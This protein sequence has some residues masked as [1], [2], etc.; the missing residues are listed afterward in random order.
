M[1]YLLKLLAT[2]TLVF[3]VCLLGLC[4][5]GSDDDQEGGYQ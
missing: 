4:P 1:I 2:V 5:G 3:L